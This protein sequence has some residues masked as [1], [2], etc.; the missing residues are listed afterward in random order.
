MESV[1]QPKITKASLACHFFRSHIALFLYLYKPFF[2]LTSYTDLAASE[3]ARIEPW[4]VLATRWDFDE[5]LRA[6]SHLL[7]IFSILPCYTWDVR[8]IYLEHILYRQ[9]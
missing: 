6:K 9:S 4:T 1:N 5:N 3:D 2:H 7:F 8:G